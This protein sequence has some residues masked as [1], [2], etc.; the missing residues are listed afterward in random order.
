[1]IQRAH[2]AAVYASAFSIVSIFQDPAPI[3]APARPVMESREFLRPWEQPGWP[4]GDLTLEA[5]R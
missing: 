2:G 3:S 5:N 1:M 4:A